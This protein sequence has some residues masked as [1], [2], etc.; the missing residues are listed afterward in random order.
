MDEAL[1]ACVIAADTGGVT[2]AR[3]EA[4]AL[5]CLSVRQSLQA[6]EHHDD[7]DDRG[8]HRA[9]SN[10][11]EEVSEGFVGKELVTLTAQEGVDRAVGQ[12]L[13]TE[14]RHVIEQI[15]LIIGHTECH[16]SLRVADYNGEILPELRPDRESRV[17]GPCTKNTSH[18]MRPASDRREQPIGE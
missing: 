17:R 10:L 13:L 7:G 18:P 4:E 16:R 2:P 5:D 12:G 8:G 6:L 11:V 15:D 9:P 14:P 1:R 3:V